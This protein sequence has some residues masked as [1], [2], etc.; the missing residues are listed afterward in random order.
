MY[1]ALESSD[2]ISRSTASD[3]FQYIKDTTEKPY[4]A[5]RGISIYTMHRAYFESR[6]YDERYW[7]RYFDT[8]AADR[9]NRP[10]AQE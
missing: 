8:L 3:P 7:T 6:L 2:R 10:R 5:E 4:I 9:F 1:A